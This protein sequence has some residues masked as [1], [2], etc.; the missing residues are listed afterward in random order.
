MRPCGIAFAALLLALSSPLTAAPQ[1]EPTPVGEAMPEVQAESGPVTAAPD[2]SQAAPAVPPPSA[3]IAAGLPEDLAALLATPAS[4][5]AKDAT[6]LN[7]FYAARGFQPLWS[8]SARALTLIERLERA[9]SEGLNPDQLLD[10]AL[11]LPVESAERELALTQAYLRYA[12]AVGF[13]L[14]D[15]QAV[16]RNWFIARRPFD[17]VPLLEQLA[18]ADDLGTLLDGLPPVDPGYARLRKALAQ[19]RVVAAEGG[20]PQLPPEAEGLKLE[21]GSQGPVV[22]AL[23]ARLAATDGL[24]A[25]AS[26]EEAELFDEAVAAAVIRFQLRNGLEPD[27]VVGKQTQGVLATPVEER[28]EQVVATMER[29]R[30][31][32]PDRGP[33]YLMVNVPAYWLEVVKEGAVVL[34]MKVVAG[35]PTR[36]TPSF[37]SPM[38]HLVLNPTWT[39]PRRILREDIIPAIRRDPDYLARKNF[40]LLDGRGGGV[41]EVD[42]STLNWDELNGRNFPYQVRR[43]PGPHNDLGQVK[44]QMK[45]RFDIYLH[46]TPSRRLFDKARRAYSSGCVRLEQP[47]RLAQLVMGWDEE[48]LRRALAP[49]KTRYIPLPEEIPVYITYES[50]WVD[51]DGTLQFR[52]DIYRR[53]KAVA[54]AV[55]GL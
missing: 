38:T 2:P 23:R 12:R 21:L 20:W 6:A 45:N 15:P 7:D 43:D 4:D 40:R 50:V 17:P 44:F 10:R 25:V 18:T 54:E 35:R 47:L 34:A 3:P 33:L 42:P 51:P 11:F 28:I 14:P 37:V 41:E 1:A 5:S 46:D 19:L 26:P 53:D 52:A 49:G 39:V 31:L 48:Q 55:M 24:A 13:G 9:G 16:D 8:D 36:A 32:T 30:W 29:K 27:G 22:A